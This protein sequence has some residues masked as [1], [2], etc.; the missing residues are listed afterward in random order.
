MAHYGS[1]AYSLF[2]WNHISVFERPFVKRFA[3]CYQTVVCLSCSVCNVGVLWP[4]GSNKLGMEVG[5]GPGHVVLDGDPSPPHQKGKQPVHVCFGQ[6]AWWIK[7]PLGTKVDREVD[8]GPSD[9]VIHGD[10]AP[11]KGAQPPIFGPCLLWPN[12]WM[13]ED[14]IWYRGRPRPRR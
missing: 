7:M 11:P 2:R 3:L 13:D 9:F 6:T 5:L 4:N 1:K 10:P 8:V 12:G 14:T